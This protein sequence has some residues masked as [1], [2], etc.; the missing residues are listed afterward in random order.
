MFAVFSTPPDVSTS[1]TR[2]EE[3]SSEG[4]GVAVAQARSPMSV[5]YPVEDFTAIVPIRS[6]E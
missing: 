5:S 6:C 2:P 4:L 3:V 1:E